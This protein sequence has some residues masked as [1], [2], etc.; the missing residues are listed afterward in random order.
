MLL[1]EEYDFSFFFPGDNKE[2]TETLERFSQGNGES[3]IYLWGPKGTGKSHLMQSVCLNAADN[4]LACSYLPIERLKE[5]GAEI[6]D[7]LESQNI[8]CIDD[9]DLLVGDPQW[10]ECLFHL[11][12][13]IRDNNNRLLMS[14]SKS[15]RQQ[16]CVLPDLHSR[17]TWG[18][19]FQLKGLNDEEKIIVLQRSADRRGFRLSNEVAQYIFNRCTRDFSSL[20][21]VLDKLDKQSL[22]Q[23]RKLTIPFVKEVMS[24]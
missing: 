5:Y 1:K 15:P 9:I 21:H 10:E 18:L 14:A 20:F 4:N 17:L 8:V 12:N 16:V 3:F 19:T 24:W 11:F 7:G 13:K 6:F 23:K 2:A 22:Q